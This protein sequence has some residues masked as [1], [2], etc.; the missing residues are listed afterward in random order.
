MLKRDVFLLN[1]SNALTDFTVEYINSNVDKE[2]V[3][4][5]RNTK[6]A[7]WFGEKCQEKWGTDFTPS[8]LRIIKL[9]GETTEYYHCLVQYRK[10]V[11]PVLLF[12]PK[13]AVLRNFLVGD[14]HSVKVDFDRY[15][16][17][18]KTRRPENPRTLKPHQEEAVK[19]LLSRKKY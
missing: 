6:I 7:T 3:D 17:L 12:I 18:S 16:R 5:N 8:I 1:K 14:Y 13:K 15:N 9:L 4:I 2:P 10:T 19:F 11:D